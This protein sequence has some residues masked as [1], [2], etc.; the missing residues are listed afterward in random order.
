MTDHYSVLSKL[1]IGKERLKQIK[2]HRKDKTA[3]EQ[4][5]IRQSFVDAFEAPF[6]NDECAP[7]DVQAEWSCVRKAFETAETMLPDSASLPRKPWIA[8]AR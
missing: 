2:C 7:E 6:Q 5:L 1:G 8:I 4:P 3:L